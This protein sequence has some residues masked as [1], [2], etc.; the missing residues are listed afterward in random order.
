MR[1]HDGIEMRHRCL[2]RAV[3]KARRSIARAAAG[4][5]LALRHAPRDPAGARPGPRFGSLVGRPHHIAQ[6]GEPGE[7]EQAALGAMRHLDRDLRR[8]S[9]SSRRMAFLTAMPRMRA[10]EV[11][12]ITGAAA[13]TSTAA[14]A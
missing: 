2:E 12:E 11:A 14:P 8:A 7:A 9:S 1:R 5:G 3:S 10:S 6:R 4:L 13:S